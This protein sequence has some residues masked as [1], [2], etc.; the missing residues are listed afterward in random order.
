[1][2]ISETTYIYSISSALPLQGLP[3]PCLAA[4]CVVHPSPM[5]GVA[6]LGVRTMD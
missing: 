1:M 3:E 4:L 6:N 2:I 5:R